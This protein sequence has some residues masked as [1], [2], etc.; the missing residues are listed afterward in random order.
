MWWSLSDRTKHNVVA[1]LL[2]D[3]RGTFLNHHIRGTGLNGHHI[4]GT[5]FTSWLNL[6]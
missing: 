2:C 6:T 4:C 3:E 1:E 5:G